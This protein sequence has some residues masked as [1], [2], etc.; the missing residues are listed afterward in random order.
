ML[1]AGTVAVDVP[2]NALGAQV[3]LRLLDEGHEPVPAN[4]PAPQR[5]WVI[6]KKDALQVRGEGARKAEYQV[7]AKA[8]AVAS[9]E[10]LQRASMV[11]TTA[12]QG[13]ETT[14]P[15]L[16]ML[17]G[18]VKAKRKVAL[19][20]LEA[21][22]GL[23][24]TATR[25]RAILCVTLRAERLLL[26]A[27]R[28]GQRCEARREASEPMAEAILGRLGFAL[29]ERVPS[30]EV[31][32]PT[33]S[34]PARSWAWALRAAGGVMGRARAVDGSVALGFS[35]FQAKGSFRPGGRV[36]LTLTQASETSVLAWEL[37]AVAGF[38]G[39]LWLAE[40]WRAL[41][42]LRAG[43][44]MHA[45]QLR[46]VLSGAG[47]RFDFAADIPLGVAWQVGSGLWL[48]LHLVPGVEHRDRQHS[49]GENV[50]WSRG[51][52]RVQGLLGLAYADF[53]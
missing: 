38:G 40:D 51:A 23:T 39:R 37:L 27:A 50:I 44:H 26:G 21:G 20:V 24:N 14:A 48:E 46:E 31:G 43:V 3:V 2:R 1:A 4:V 19:Q 49:L 22:W 18:D 15:D 11:L 32:A 28:A 41:A 33:V 5:L 52:F 42:G 16:L 35:F 13:R 47:Q 10:L 53:F 7:R 8:S 30:V 36:D 25:A 6:R 34:A 9:L 12:G 29:A 45:Y 17:E